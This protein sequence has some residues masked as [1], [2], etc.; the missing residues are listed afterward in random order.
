MLL[1]RRAPSPHNIVHQ[2]RS[3]WYLHFTREVCTFTLSRGELDP[4][5]LLATSARRG[6]AVPTPGRTLATVSARRCT[7]GRVTQTSQTETKSTNTART[8]SMLQTETKTTC[9]AYVLDSTNRN[10]T[11]KHQPQACA[12]SRADLVRALDRPKL[13]ELCVDLLAPH[14]MSGCQDRRPKN[15]RV[16]RSSICLR[17]TWVIERALGDG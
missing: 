7:R 5:R 3:A 9:A 11:H 1:P 13:R 10:K 8:P 16:G 6:P 17:R 15:T 4:T 12:C 14:P 2:A